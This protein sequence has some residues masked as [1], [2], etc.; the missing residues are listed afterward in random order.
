MTEEQY[1]ARHRVKERLSA[2]LSA[3][4]E[5]Q[6]VTERLATLEARMVNVGAQV[7]DGMPRGGS[8]HDPMPDLLDAKTKLVER[9]RALAETLI[10][11]QI[12]IEEAIA[13]LDSTERMVMRHRYIE[14]LT[15]EQ[16]CVAMDY[17]WRQ[18]HNIHARAL[19]RLAEKEVEKC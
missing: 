9:Y 19:D 1:K 17:S 6:Q 12:A 7:I 16:V 8:G 18:T 4:K 3:R 5:H 14:G 13:E 15:W 11:S 2:Y 10:R